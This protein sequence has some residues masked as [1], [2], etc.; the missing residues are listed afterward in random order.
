MAFS[1][2]KNRCETRK[3]ERAV[4]FMYG[5]MSRDFDVLMYAYLSAI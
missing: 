4:T 3:K 5:C 1:S 2:F